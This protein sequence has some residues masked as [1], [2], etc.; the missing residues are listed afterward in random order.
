MRTGTAIRFA[1]RHLD[2]SYAALASAVLWRCLFALLPMQ[3]PV[4]TG[5]LVDI[6]QGAPGAVYGYQLPAGSPRSAVGVIVL[7][8]AFTAVATGVSAYQRSVSAARVGRRFVSRVLKAVVVKWENA[9]LA[10]HQQYGPAELLNRTLLDPPAIRAFV[11]RAFVDLLSLAIRVAWPAAMLFVI[12]PVLA[13]I[14]LSALPLQRLVTWTLERRLQEAASDARHSRAELTCAVKENLDAIETVQALCAEDRMMSRICS[15]ADELEGGEVR[16]KQYAGMISGCVYGLTAAFYALSLGFGAVRVMDGLLTTGELVAFAGFI[17]FLYLPFRQISRLAG[18]YRKGIV[19][20]SRIEEILQADSAVPQVADSAALQLTTGDIEFDNVCMRYG[21]RDSL[22]NISVRL[23]GRKLTAISGRSGSGKTSLLRL[24]ARLREP[25]AGCIRIDG[26]DIGACSLASL[27]DRVAVVPQRPALFSDTIL[28]NLLL[29]NPAATMEDVEVACEA[30]GAASFIRR[31]SHGY[32]TRLG[33]A[34]VSLSGGEA[35][36]IAIARAIL[37]R[38]DV[39][40]LDEPT[41]ALDGEAE[42]AL[43]RTLQSLTSRMTV[44]VV[45]HRPN[46]LRAASFV[47]VL[48]HGRLVGTGTHAGLLEQ[49]GAYRSVCGWEESHDVCGALDA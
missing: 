8:L 5:A 15:L 13:L 23:P 3:A 19:G 25:S 2:G 48:D 29:G 35:H 16:S 1:L 47:V 33:E 7:A 45:A 42:A 43:M 11:E 21:D 12:D 46:T 6:L 10:Y 9:S 22:C 14:P 17:S 27:R 28:A 24:M 44:V 32:E 31:L 41:A 30:A 37:R 39:L 36:R 38:P 18:A 49:P 20:I 26:Q 40:L 34:G 4:L